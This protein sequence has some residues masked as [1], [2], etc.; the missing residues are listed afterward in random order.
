LAIIVAGV[1]VFTF[2][3]FTNAVAARLATGFIALTVCATIPVTIA[4]YDPIFFQTIRI[5]VAFRFWYAIYRAGVGAFAFSRVTLTITTWL[6]TFRLAFT[7]DAVPMTE[8]VDIPFHVQAVRIHGAFKGLDTVVWT[9]ADVFTCATQT[10]AAVG[11]NEAAVWWGNALAIISHKGVADLF[12][13]F[14]ANVILKH[15]AHFTFPYTRD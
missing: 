13:S 5:H 7:I 8:A 14:A 9:V 6:T 1:H 4:I 12:Q 11:T 3:L 2:L 15:A 10:V